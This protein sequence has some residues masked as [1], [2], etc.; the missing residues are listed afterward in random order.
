MCVTNRDLWSVTIQDCVYHRFPVL[1]T[2][3]KLSNLFLIAV[4]CYQHACF[5][6]FAM[7]DS[8]VIAT[9]VLLAAADDRS[10]AKVWRDAYE[11]KVR[12]SQ[13]LQL[14]DAVQENKIPVGSQK[15]LSQLKDHMNA[16]EDTSASVTVLFVAVCNTCCQSIHLLAGGGFMQHCVLCCA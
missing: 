3:L 4:R 12:K 13:A 2:C 7:S 6:A 11:G 9:K 16:L 1:E 8:H 14:A 15:L 10:L 5:D